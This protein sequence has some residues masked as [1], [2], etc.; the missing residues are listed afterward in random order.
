MPGSTTNVLERKL[1]VYKD[2]SLKKKPGEMTRRLRIDILGRE[3]LKKSST[4]G[5]NGWTKIPND[6]YQDVQSKY[7]NYES[8]HLKKR[9]KSMIVCNAFF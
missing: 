6:V 2:I 4:T 5:K 8:A 9:I 3:K 1:N 7:E